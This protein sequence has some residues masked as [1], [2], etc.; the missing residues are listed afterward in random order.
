MQISACRMLLVGIEKLIKKYQYMKKTL[1]NPSKKRGQK[2]E[3][4]LKKCEKTG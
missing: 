3:F 4:L 2:V 1:P